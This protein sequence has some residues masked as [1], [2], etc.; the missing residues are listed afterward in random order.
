MYWP[1]T[2]FSA[3]P[4]VR[5]GGD[6]SEIPL[7][8]LVLSNMRQFVKYSRLKQFALR[9]IFFYLSISWFFL[10]KKRKERSFVNFKFGQTIPLQALASTLDEEELSDLKDQFD[11]IDVDKN[12]AISLEEMRQV[13]IFLHILVVEDQS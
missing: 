2:T 13:Y 12:G 9:V 8:I 1:S 6:A 7:D 3:H 5:E 4:W 10:R 11:A